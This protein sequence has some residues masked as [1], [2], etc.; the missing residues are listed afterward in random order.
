MISLERSRLL[1]QFV[2]SLAILGIAAVPVLR[3]G[4]PIEF[5]A[6]TTI[7]ALWF[8]APSVSRKEE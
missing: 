8:P 5:G 7:A 2:I 3:D 1:I 6:L 4:K